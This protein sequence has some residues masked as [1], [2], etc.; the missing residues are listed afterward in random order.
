MSGVAGEGLDVDGENA[1]S[2]CRGKLNLHSVLV[3]STNDISLSLRAV[4]FRKED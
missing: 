1:E 3:Q 4:L 2:G